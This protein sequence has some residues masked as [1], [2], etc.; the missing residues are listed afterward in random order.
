MGKK[1]HRSQVGVCS[2]M[3]KSL[4]YLGLR[5]EHED[6]IERLSLMEQGVCTELK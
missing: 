5:E 1:L 2:I 6:D 3:N 4:N